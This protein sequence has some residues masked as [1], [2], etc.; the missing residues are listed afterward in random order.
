MSRTEAELGQISPEAAK[1]GIE[2]LSIEE[3]K[4]RVEAALRQV[5]QDYKNG[6]Y[7][8]SERIRKTEKILETQP[9]EIINWLEESIQDGPTKASHTKRVTVFLAGTD[10]QQ[11]GQKEAVEPKT[12]A[13]KRLP[14]GVRKHIRREKALKRRN[15]SWIKSSFML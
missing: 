8:L 13:E 5:G 14:A 2:E 1:T 4:K 12:R 9:Q 11:I 15:Y 10:S 6:L 7:N 3:R